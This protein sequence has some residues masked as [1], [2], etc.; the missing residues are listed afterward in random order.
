ME[1]AIW[2]WSCE[3]ITQFYVVLHF[4]NITKLHKY[5]NKKNISITFNNKKK[6][7]TIYPTK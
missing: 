4:I 1:V 3:I 2:V 7:T 5:Y 6:H